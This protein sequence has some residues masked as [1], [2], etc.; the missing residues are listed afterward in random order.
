MESF[1]IQNDGD[2][3]EDMKMHESFNK[4]DND[5]SMIWT[6]DDIANDMTTINSD[7]LHKVQWSDWL[8]TEIVIHIFKYLDWTSLTK[9][10]MTNAFWY[11]LFNSEDI[12][13]AFRNE[14]KSIFKLSGLYEA[15]KKYIGRFRDW[16][17]MFIF[18]PRVRFD[19]IYHATSKYWHRGIAEFGDSKPLHRVTYF[20]YIKFGADGSILYSQEACELDKFV[21][22]VKRRRIKFDKGNYYVKDDL[23]NIEISRG[24]NAFW[25]L[26][27]FEGEMFK[28]SDAFELIS[29]H[30]IDLQAQT[31]TPIRETHQTSKFEFAK[32]KL[33]N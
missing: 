10:A 5:S 14:W 30:I 27:K 13:L 20:I 18:R 21:E 32:I 26:Y 6:E 24:R 4:L 28:Q 7:W 15:S 25:Y 2:E 19:G 1:E 9:V 33:P 29:K 16:K 12:Q 22:K 17:H 8:P 31:F 11:S 23:L 3:H